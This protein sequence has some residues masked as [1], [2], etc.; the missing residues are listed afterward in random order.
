MYHFNDLVSLLAKAEISSPRLEARLILSSVLHCEADEVAAIAYDLNPSDFCRLNQML[1][2]RVKHFPL[3][4][5]LGFKDFYK[6]RFQV[7]E[8]VLSPRPDTEVLVEEAILL[9]R[10]HKFHSILD[11]GTGSG[12]I[13]LSLLAEFPNLLGLGV[14]ASSQALEI[15]MLN[16]VH[17]GVSAQ[18]SW[19]NLSWFAD[20]FINSLGQKFD[21]IVSNPPYI[22]RQDIAQLDEEVKSHDPLSALDGGVDGYEHYLQ[23]AKLAPKILNDGGYILL[24]G[25][26]NQAQDINN[27]FQAEGLKHVKIV[28]DLNGIERCIILKK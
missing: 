19:L 14:D 5:I 10:Q 2:Q 27:I 17:L 13:L 26:I 6:Y 15:A 22:P 11:L 9:L 20:D 18:V 1:E 16:S 4:K 28:D 8:D 24:E 21:I 7:N 3:D 25:G 23:I 12:C